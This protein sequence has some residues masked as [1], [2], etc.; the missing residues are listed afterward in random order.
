MEIIQVKGKISESTIIVG[1]SISNLSKY[2]P[3]KG[4]YIITDENVDKLY[5]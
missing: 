5:G 4:V 2:I 1:E 3:G